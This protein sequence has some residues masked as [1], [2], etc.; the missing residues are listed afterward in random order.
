MDNLKEELISIKRKGN[1]K[2]VN[3]VDGSLNAIPERIMEICK[4]MIDNEIGIKWDLLGNIKGMS[5]EQAKILANAGCEVANIGVESGSSTLRKLMNKPIESNQEIF[6]AFDYLNRVGIIS[7]AYFF[8]GYPGENDSTINET[9]TLINKSAMDLCRIALYRPRINSTMCTEKNRSATKL[10]GRGYLWRHYTCDSLRASQ[11]VKDIF[12]SIRPIFDPERGVFEL[13]RHG[14]SRD[15]AM[16]INNHKNR[17]AQFI[18]KGES[19][20]IIAEETNKLANL[21]R[22]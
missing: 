3:F 16:L 1:I 4:F 11:Y 20:K 15:R 10:E 17:I 13:I 6:N 5:Y 8:V 14:Y 12:T 2:Y 21:A 22:K 7:R 9:I 19:M 18:A